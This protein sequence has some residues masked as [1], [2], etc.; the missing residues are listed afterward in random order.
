MMPPSVPNK[1]LP[2]LPAGAVIAI[3]GPAA[4]GKSSVARTLAR[5]LG[6]AYVNS[7]AFYRAATWFI[8]EK[9][10]DPHEGQAVAEALARARVEAGLAGAVE[11][12]GGAGESFIRLDGRAP[13]EEALRAEAVNSGVSTPH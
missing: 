5:R 2:A 3:D 12:G 9:G 1:D 11:N 4:S 8:L 7:G 6:F 13:S 10:I